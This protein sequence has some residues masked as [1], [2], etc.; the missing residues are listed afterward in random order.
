MTPHRTKAAFDNPQAYERFMGRW[1]AN[2]AQL[3]LDFAGLADGDRVLD[4]GSGTGNLALAVH[5]RAPRAQVVGIDPSPGYVEFARS[6]TTA[7][8][9]RFE[10]GVADA[11]PFADRSFD[12]ALCQLVFNFIPDGALALREL[13]RV[14]LS[15]GVIAA[16]LW[17]LDGGMRMLDAFWE[18]AGANSENAGRFGERAT[19]YTKEE[20]T[21]LWNEAGLRDVTTGEL[22]LPIE[23]ASFDDYWSPFLLGQGPAGAYAISLSHDKLAVVRERLRTIVLGGRPDG[24]IS[25]P[26]R[27]FAVRGVV[28]AS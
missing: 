2:L 20:I 23:F 10:R 17:R 7:A 5:A 27:A 14:T 21:A 24:L 19:A 15:G 1:S 25:L 8:N 11:L 4:V 22:V 9:V 3:F 18:A 13:R 6:R 16:V 26:A 28:P 12:R